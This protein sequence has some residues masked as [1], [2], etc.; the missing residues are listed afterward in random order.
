MNSK[1]TRLIMLVL[2][3]A[4]FV[5]FVVAIF[6]GSSILTHKSKK[7]VDLKL[8]STVLDSQLTSLVQA[9]KDV[10][11][12]AYFNE[13][14]GTVIPNDKDQAQTVIDIFQLAN[15]SGIMIQ[16]ITFP[17][18]N[19]GASGASA[20]GSSSNAISQAKSVSG[21]K[22]LYS[23]ELNITPLTGAQTPADKNVTYAKFLDF[24]GRI[25]NNRRTA[26][27]TQVNIQPISNGGGPSQFINFSLTINI[28]IKP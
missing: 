1:R 17:A 3:G 11:Q 4:L 21:I 25:E 22:G 9:K 14:A 15:Q 20:T 24:L 8:Q 5:V 6:M 27:I 10:S 23:L 18:S 2:L 16:N 26:Q 13:V 19:L 7:L 12:Y 28:F